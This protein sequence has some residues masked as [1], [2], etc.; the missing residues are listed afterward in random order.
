[1]KFLQYLFFHQINHSNQL[2][3]QNVNVQDFNKINMSKLIRNFKK[4][5]NSKSILITG[6][7]H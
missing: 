3:C 5:I 6:M 4:N 1:M 2:N 7:K